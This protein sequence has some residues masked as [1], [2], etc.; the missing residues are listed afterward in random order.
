MLNGPP[1]RDAM[2]TSTRVGLFTVMVLLLT[3]L[4]ASSAFTT[5]SLERDTS[6]DVVSDDAGIIALTDGT[7]GGVVSVD[8]S[9]ELS[10]DFRVGSAGGVNV[11]S[12]YELGDPASPT[13][14]QAFNITNQDSVGHTIGLNYSVAS[15]DGVSDGSP[16][17][18]FQVYDSTGTQVATEDESSG[19]G[20]FSAA[21]GETFYVVVVVDTTV[22]SLDQSSDL[23]GTL[24]VTGS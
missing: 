22:G 18:E 12:T 10:I 3:G 2:R 7:S 24:R 8:S 14:V 19:T 9:G 23:S 4:I 13:T 6:I 15:G 1:G 16:S 11:N 5:A 20:S 21:S 17:V